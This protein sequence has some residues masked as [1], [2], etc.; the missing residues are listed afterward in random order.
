MERKV[1]AIHPAL[2]DDIGDLVTRRPVPG[3]ASS[4]SIRSCS[5]TTTGRR[6]IRRTTAACRSGRI[7]IAASR[8]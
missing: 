2:R 4:R 3:R 5:S 8:P 1:I 6:S 7:R